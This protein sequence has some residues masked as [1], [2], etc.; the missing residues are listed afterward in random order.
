MMRPDG[1]LTPHRGTGAVGIDLS[2][3]ST[4]LADAAG[5]VLRVQ[6]KPTR[7]ADPLTDTL[8]RLERI[9][10]A[11]RQW[12]VL[13]ELVTIEGPSYGQGRQGGEHARAGLWW[14]VVRTLVDNGHR[15]IVVPP[16]TLK[17]YATGKGNASKDTVLAAVVKRYPAHDVTGNDVADAVTLAAIGARILGRPIDDPMPKTHLRALD[18]LD[19]LETPN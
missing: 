18:K 16:A 4:G 7:G 12:A 17:T 6:T 8:A 3:A 14:A 15:I 5:S 2:L 10:G 9:T 19:R 13:A 1:P 11:V